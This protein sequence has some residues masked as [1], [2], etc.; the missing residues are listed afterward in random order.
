MVASFRDDVK[1][2][3]ACKHNK[4]LAVKLAKA[5]IPVFL[6]KADKTPMPIAWEDLDTAISAEVR[7][8]KRRKF[9]DKNGFEP[10]HVGCTLN[11]KLIREWFS[12][13]PT[14]M[15][16]ISCGPAGVLVVDNDVKDRKGVL[17]NG[18]EMFN[19]FCAEHGGM[20]KGVVEINTQGGGR[21]CYFAADETNPLQCSPGALKKE[22]ESDVKGAKGFVVAPSAVRAHDGKRY[23]SDADCDAFV[24]AYTARKLVP[25]P[26][27]IR[28]AIG[29]KPASAAVRVTAGQL[30]QPL[31]ALDEN[32]WPDYAETFGEP[33]LGARYDLEELRREDPEFASVVEDSDGNRSDF[34]WKSARRLLQKWPDMTVEELAVYYAE[35]ADDAGELTGDGKGSGYYSHTDIAK[36]WTKNRIASPP[37]ALRVSSPSRAAL[38][39]ARVRAGGSRPNVPRVTRRMPPP[40]LD[41]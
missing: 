12:K 24:K 29:T 5:G 2:D 25:V 9:V 16:A 26:Q 15:P 36:E 32:D 19:E 37:S 28:D 4:E 40:L 6:C 11:T 31:K 3:R 22:C 38:A 8:A 21:H 14:A 20:P 23:G 18:V 35:H 27:F 13:H 41:R 10:L 7:E 39:A 1:N 34:R 30:A 33:A 17:R